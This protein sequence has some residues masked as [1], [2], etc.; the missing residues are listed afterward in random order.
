MIADKHMDLFGFTR[1]MKGHDGSFGYVGPQRD[2]TRQ[3]DVAVFHVDL[4]SP[5]KRTREHNQGGKTCR[6]RITISFLQFC[7]RLR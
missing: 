1:S 5:Y 2:V 4:W 7:G 6:T 3:N